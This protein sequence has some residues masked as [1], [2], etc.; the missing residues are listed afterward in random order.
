MPYFFA[1]L[2]VAI[3]LA[4]VGVV[5]AAAVAFNPGIG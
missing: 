5:L 1:A 2:K 3:T 4:F